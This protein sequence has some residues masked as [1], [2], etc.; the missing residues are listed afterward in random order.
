M[1]TDDKDPRRAG[2]ARRAKRVRLGSQSAQRDSAA[3]LNEEDAETSQATTQA[4]HNQDLISAALKASEDLLR[5]FVNDGAPQE[6]PRDEPKGTHHDEPKDTKHRSTSQRPQRQG[7]R[8]SR[9][10]GTDKAR[11]KRKAKGQR[12]ARNMTSSASAVP[13]RRAFI[14]KAASPNDPDH[15]PPP[16]TPPSEPLAPFP[17]EP[18]G[19]EHSHTTSPAESQQAPAQDALLEEMISFD[20]A[21]EFKQDDEDPLSAFGSV[22]DIS[23]IPLDRDPYSRSTASSQD[24]LSSTAQDDNLTNAQHDPFAL[25]PNYDELS[26]QHLVKPHSLQ[27]P[28]DA[29]WSPARPAHEDFDELPIPQDFGDA[30]GSPEDFDAMDPSSPNVNAPSADAPLF[31]DRDLLSLEA[32]LMDDDGLLDYSYEDPGDLDGGLDEQLDDGLL[33]P[34]GGD[35]VLEMGSSSQN[36]FDALDAD[37]QADHPALDEYDQYPDPVSLEASYTEG[38]NFEAD[39]ISLNDEY[40]QD[41]RQEATASAASR[42][43][44][45]SI[46]Y[47]AVHEVVWDVMEEVLGGRLV[48]FEEH[49]IQRLERRLHSM[50][51]DNTSSKSNPPSL[52]IPAMTSSRHAV[53]LQGHMP[54]MAVLPKDWGKRGKD[55]PSAREDERLS[56]FFE[57]MKRRGADDLH[58]HVGAHPIIRIQGVVEALRL[59]T[60]RRE[61]WTVLLR[62]ICPPG[63]WDQWRSTGDVDFIHESTHGRYHVNMFRQRQG[64]GAV[65]RRIPDQAP[66]LRDLRMP[67]HLEKLADLR[68]GLC[69]FSGPYGSGTSN[70]VAALVSLI[71]QRHT[72]RIITIEDPIDF[73]HTP[74]QSIIHQRI[75]GVHAATFADAL[76]D[77]LR[78]APEVIVIGEMIDRATITMAIDAARAGI[79]VYGTVRRRTA[80]ATLNALIDAYPEEDQARF[81]SQLA[82]VLRVVV[83]Q[84]LL[85]RLTGGR[86]PAVELLINTVDAGRMIRQN[87]LDALDGLIDDSPH[88]GMQRMDQSLAELVQ[89]DE[90]SEEAAMARAIAPD[91][92]HLLIYGHQDEDDLD[93]DDDFQHHDD[94]DEDDDDFQHH[95][96]FIG[97][98][99]DHDEALNVDAMGLENFSQHSQ[100]HSQH[101]D[102]I[103]DEQD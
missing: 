79:L 19:A 77:A 4:A 8:G 44:T 82:D 62:P 49:I 46:D 53:G 70:T 10:F 29:P 16:A 39:S 63:K 22:N 33:N 57:L 56:F 55:T 54:T 25:E 20:D 27:G 91:E 23:S 14:N 9:L 36:P 47:N 1:A 28:P 58:L 78:E 67:M 98:L 92:L 42:S 85:E 71:N 99:E 96:E 13:V 74:E 21:L 102:S 35:F 15:Q 26:G 87:E 86:L 6:A 103:Y 50:S 93:E 30:L 73:V 94:L 84:Q 81:R 5:D 60:L 43:S 95:D 31:D 34:Q 69:L 7:R 90:I 11:W 41:L 32:P 48:Q 72:H 59:R 24:S 45:N 100:T 64:G 88:L 68:G 76:G 18:S 2:S 75:I 97:E 80:R 89:R 12:D 83:C 51:L 61:D 3:P 40:L 65:L 66:R 38:L 17:D 101:D 52:S 37:A